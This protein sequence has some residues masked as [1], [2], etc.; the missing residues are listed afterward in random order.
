MD[1]NMILIKNVNEWH[2]HTKKYKK[3][4][5]IQMLKS[6]EMRKFHL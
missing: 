4:K 6:G 5:T 3:T 1:Y 2:K